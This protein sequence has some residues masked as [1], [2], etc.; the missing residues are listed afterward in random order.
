MIIIIN[1][2]CVSGSSEIRN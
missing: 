2:R 1:L